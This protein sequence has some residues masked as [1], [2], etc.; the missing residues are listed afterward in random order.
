LETREK[1]GITLFQTYSKLLSK[2]ANFPSQNRSLECLPNF[3]SELMPYPLKK[4]KFRSLECAYVIGASPN[5]SSS[6]G[7]FQT[8]PKIDESKS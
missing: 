4:E 3:S 5:F 8:G 1:F 2:N 6:F 7:G